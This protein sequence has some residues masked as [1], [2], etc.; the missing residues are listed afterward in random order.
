MKLFMLMFSTIF[1]LLCICAFV[2]QA[3]FS[4]E[5]LLGIVAMSLLVATLGRI[6]SK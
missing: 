4:K 3:P 6:G 2:L 5:G 1:I